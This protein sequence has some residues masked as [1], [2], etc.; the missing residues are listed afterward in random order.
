[1][2]A[3]LARELAPRLCRKDPVTGENCSWNHG[4]WQCLR[5]M[6][7]AVT[8]ADQADFYHRA[9]QSVTG[10]SGMPRVLISGTTDY[11][12]LAHVLAFHRERGLEPVVTVLDIC[13]TPLFLNRWYAA[14][15]SAGVECT[16]SDI[17][18]YDCA[19]PFD[20]V[21]TD[22]FLGQFSP[23]KRIRLLEKWR[24]LLR[25]GGA[26][27]TV[28]RVRAGADAAPIGFSPEQAR[29][30]RSTIVR[31]AAAMPAGL[32]ADPAEIARAADLYLSRQQSWPVRSREEV[33]QLFAGCG[34]RVDELS[35]SRRTAAARRPP[36]E[37]ASPG[38]GEQLRIIATRL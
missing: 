11:S 29:A 6:D 17:L 8:P 26:V 1:M 19:A 12:M 15:A 36:K 10:R 33:R 7:L 9:F 18:D 13:D 22:S 2:S 24:Q 21:C 32:Q 31:K 27:I 34:F 5:L 30:L 25:P 3:P 35:D 37:A 4:F 38:E 28:T 20:A 23:D 14:R 16:R